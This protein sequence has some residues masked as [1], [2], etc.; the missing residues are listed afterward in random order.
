MAELTAT[1]QRKNIVFLVRQVV[2][3]AIQDVLAD[4]DYGLSLNQNFVKR[5]KKSVQSKKAGKV[6]ALDA[7]LRQYQ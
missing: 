1:I 3:E 2:A 5:L 7:I 6:V 4:P